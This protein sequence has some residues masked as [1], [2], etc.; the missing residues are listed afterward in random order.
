[1]TSEKIFIA[2]HNGMVGKALVRAAKA[3]RYQQIITAN[4]KDLDLRDQA[5]VESF[6]NDKKPDIVVIAAAK[7]GGIWANSQYPAEFIYD[8]LSLEINLIEGSRRAGVS[9]LLFL[10]SSCIYPKFAEQPVQESALNT[11]PLEPT[12]EAYAIAKIAGLK[13]CQFYRQQYG[14][15][16][17]SVMP[18]NL[19]GPGDN[20]HAQNSH[21]IPALI[22][23]F[24]E[25]KIQG[26]QEIEMWGTGTPLREFLHCD[27]L[28][29]ACFH[30]LGLENPPDWINV[31]SGNEISIAQLA[32]MVAEAVGF[33]GRIV[34]DLTKPD[35]CP[36]K[37]LDTS[38]ILATGWMPQHSLQDGL[39]A[40]YA[41]FLRT[42]KDGTARVG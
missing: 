28:A 25:A 7:V 1:M 30:L 10:G 17:H 40:A 29:E 41:D 19:Y 33:E 26:D 20:Y 21:V 2:G 38:A 3:R 14:L 6:L 35:G 24:H 5:V 32:Q 9:R 27:D 16:Y 4:R 42:L 34:K 23:R 39:S 31:G 37:F 36:R 18:T 13:M 11:A 8:N 15:L 22:R 12:N